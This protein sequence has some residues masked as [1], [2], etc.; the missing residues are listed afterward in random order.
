MV[1]STLITY[2]R[3]RCKKYCC[4]KAIIR[5]R[6]LDW[7][8]DNALNSKLTSLQSVLIYFKFSYPTIWLW[9]L[10]DYIFTTKNDVS[11]VKYLGVSEQNAQNSLGD[12]KWVWSCVNSRLENLNLLQ[13][14]TSIL[15][16]LNL[17]SDIISLTSNISSKQTLFRS[18]P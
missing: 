12:I 3:E 7:A 2:S 10:F 17:L 15:N 18:S 4:I 6:F 5:K 9:L 8:K 14:V 11:L 1:G 13:S 16:R